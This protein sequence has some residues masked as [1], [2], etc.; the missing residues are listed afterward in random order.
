MFLY[1]KNYKHITMKQTC[2][3]CRK[4]TE[5][6]ILSTRR[7][8]CKNC[9]KLAPATLREQRC[10]HRF[11]DPKTGAFGNYCNRGCG[12]SVDMTPEMMQQLQQAAQETAAEQT[13]QQILGT[14]T[15]STASTE[16]TT[17]HGENTTTTN[18]TEVL[19]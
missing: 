4:Q 15:S 6:I 9:R 7:L 5:W 11:I 18:E 3:H 12:V 13:A 14:T 8:H 17:T 19:N 16:T 2:P 10:K 1:L